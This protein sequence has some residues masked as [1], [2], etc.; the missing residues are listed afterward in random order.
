MNTY[1]KYS[2]PFLLVL[3]V[4]FT[5]IA[6]CKSDDNVSPEQIDLVKN[7]D[8]AVPLA[9]M[10]LFLEIDR[11]TED[12]R[13]GPASRALAY[14]NLAAYE[15]VTRGMPEFKSL[16]ELYP[17]LIMP[18][19][20]N[21]TYHYPTVVNAVYANLFKRFLPSDNIDPAQQS[22]LQ[23]DILAL[24]DTNNE[25]FKSIIGAEIFDRSQEHGTAIAN[26]IWEW[27]KTDPFGHAA[28]LNSR[29]EGYTPPSGP[30]LWTP[31]AP[32]FQ[33]ALFPYWGKARCFAITE[34][35]RLAKEPMVFS[36][37]PT[38]QFYA[39]ALEVR[40]TVSS[41]EFTDQWKA[42][43]W[44]D[45]TV[46]QTFSPPT[47]WISIANQV[48]EKDQCH[49]ET[50]LYAY[51]KVSL[52]LN[53]AGIA[54]WHSKY[55]FN[56][57]RPVTYINRV[58]DADW[59]PHN[60]FS[61]SYPAYPSGHAAFGAAAAEALSHVFGYDYALT[62]ASHDG[63]TEFLGMPRSFDTFYQMAE[64]NASSRID[65]GVDFRMDIEEGLRLGYQVGRK[66][67]QMPFK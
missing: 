52:A 50:A 59:L 7:E 1:H 32:D 45:E 11:Y 67:N 65:L 17:D 12:F 6:G 31:T 9:W 42:E 66:I 24:E 10:K 16:N 15:S 23:F 57:E 21:E 41:L 44:S 53:D 55:I 25:S 37:D 36:E 48:I 35:D 58:I 47:R 61:P 2:N 63:R 33:A 60:E 43:F 51:A 64:E 19:A 30:G 49:L 22:N 40:N 26:T 5:L 8:A 39:Q 14:I 34:T 3:V 62:D 4:A 38:S 29:P 54:T 56:V 13:P 18:D 20:S 27:S 46:G 28:Y